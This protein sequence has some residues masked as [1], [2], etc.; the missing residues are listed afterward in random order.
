[1]PRD[2]YAGSTVEMF[3]AEQQINL[4]A[5][6]DPRKNGLEKQLKLKQPS[7][8]QSQVVKNA[9]GPPDELQ[10]KLNLHLGKSL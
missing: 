2:P 1:M 7:K 6:P 8:L 4:S 5:S 9:G 10:E 3:K